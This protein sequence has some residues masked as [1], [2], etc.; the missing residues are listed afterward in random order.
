[1]RL[2]CVYTSNPDIKCKKRIIDLYHWQS[3]TNLNK[4]LWVI[5]ANKY[6]VKQI[7]IKGCQMFFFVF[8]FK[9]ISIL[10]F[11]FLNVD[12][13]FCSVVMIL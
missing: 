8:C 13:A 6:V 11:A 3:M 7:K 12:F 10:S 5:K 2:L 9:F 4:T 1:M